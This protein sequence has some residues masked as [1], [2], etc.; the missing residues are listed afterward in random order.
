MCS[1]I[2]AFELH[3]TKKA[4]VGKNA[5]KTRAVMRMAVARGGIHDTEDAESLKTSRHNGPL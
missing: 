4:E 3:T 2:C 5:V 1:I